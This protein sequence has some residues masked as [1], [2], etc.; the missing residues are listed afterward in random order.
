MPIVY[1]EELKVLDFVQWLKHYYFVLPDCFPFL[2][3]FL[4]SLIK[5]TLWVK[6]FYRQKQADDMR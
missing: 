5:L 6:F 1:E 4:T 3:H 2:L